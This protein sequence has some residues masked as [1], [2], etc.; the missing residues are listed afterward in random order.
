MP[1][2]KTSNK[3]RLKVGNTLLVADEA[4]GTHG[5]RAGHH[6]ATRHHA[7]VIPRSVPLAWRKGLIR[8]RGEP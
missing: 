8:R 6:P 5:D 4:G 3:N 2:N 7:T 1:P